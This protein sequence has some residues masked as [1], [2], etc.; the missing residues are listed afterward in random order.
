MS[1][2]L[3]DD[4]SSWYKRLS[5]IVGISTGSISIAG[6]SFRNVPEFDSFLKINWESGI[7][8]TRGGKFS[9]SLSLNDPAVQ[10]LAERLF[11]ENCRD[12]VLELRDSVGSGSV[13]F[14]GVV[15]DWETVGIDLNLTASQP[16]LWNTRK[17]LCRDFSILPEGAHVDQTTWLPVLFGDSDELKSVPMFSAPRVRCAGPVDLAAEEIMLAELPDWPASGRLQIN[18]EVLDYELLQADPPCLKLLTRGSA[19][20]HPNRPW[21]H[22]IPEGPLRWIAADH[23]A[24]VISAQL[25]PKNVTSFVP[26]YVIVQPLVSGIETTAIQLPKLPLNITYADAPTNYTPNFS[27][28]DWELTQPATA[29]QPL[30]AFT[31]LA[32]SLGGALFRRSNRFLWARYKRNLLTEEFRF[33]RINSAKFVF[34]A[35]TNGSWGDSTQIRIV[36]KIGNRSITALLSRTQFV[37]GEPQK[38]RLTLLSGNSSTVPVEIQRSERVFFEQIESLST[39][40]FNNQSAIYEQNDEQFASLQVTPSQG[41]LIGLRFRLLH[42]IGEPETVVRQVKFNLRARS[43]SAQRVRL[44]VSIPFLARQEKQFTLSSEWSTVSLSFTV[45]SIP[46]SSL[47]LKDTAF[48]FVVEEEGE[49][50]VSR[51]WLDYEVL[52]TESVRLPK[53]ELSTEALSQTGQIVLSNLEIDFTSILPA[54]PF[55]AFDYEGDDFE[56]FVDLA[57]AD[58]EFTLALQACHLSFDVYP[59]TRIEPTTTIYTRCRGLASES[60]GLC[61][62]ANV[63]RELISNPRFL[64]NSSNWNEESFEEIK[65]VHA[66]DNRWFIGTFVG[67]YSLETV[68]RKAI[69]ECLSTIDQQETGLILEDLSRRE[70]QPETSLSLREFVLPPPLAQ[71]AKP[72]LCAGEVL[73]KKESTGEP[74]VNIQ[75]HQGEGSEDWNLYWLRQGFSTIAEYLREVLAKTQATAVVRLAHDVQRMA[76]GSQVRFPGSLPL[77]PNLEGLLISRSWKKA[78]QLCEIELFPEWITFWQSNEAQIRLRKQPKRYQVLI[79]GTVVFDYAGGFFSLKGQLKEEVIPSAQH[80]SGFTWITES[81]R[82]RFWNQTTEQGFELTAEGDLLTT[83]PVQQLPESQESVPQEAVQTIGSD[84]Y[85][86]IPARRTLFSLSSNTIQLFGSLREFTLS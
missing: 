44:E 82:M 43:Q 72:R 21:V 1:S 29:L 8:Q 76:L 7:R 12:V 53:V 37:I 63:I 14:R 15:V 49:I 40:I 68:L 70:N 64:G 61:A 56:L 38:T 69:E 5:L 54:I 4:S 74:I 84:V 85:F 79:Q 66:Q 20:S 51:S 32:K 16:A 11:E 45:P 47:Y 62:P 24:G 39:V 58:P 81:Q 60:S 80:A 52:Q 13:L 55:Q 23:Q 30:D 6:A 78:T 71:Y 83:A 34:Q 67:R 36:C 26:D 48:K 3:I 59:A 46:L 50:D 9:V 22:L 73:L 19:R 31:P 17:L 27:A 18:D 28:V 57:N 35:R 25:V 41:N 2:L 86:S 42:M 77:L 75:L 10:D 65:G 33:S